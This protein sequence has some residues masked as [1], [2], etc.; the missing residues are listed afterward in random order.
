MIDVSAVARG[1]YGGSL[2]ATQCRYAFQGFRIVFDILDGLIRHPRIAVVG[3]F[4]II[5]VEVFGYLDGIAHSKCAFGIE[6]LLHAT[7]YFSGLRCEHVFDRVWKIRGCQLE[8]TR[9]AE[10]VI[11]VGWID[12]DGTDVRVGFV[13]QGEFDPSFAFANDG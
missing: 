1:A 5:E 6:T 2:R 4:R 10:R 11:R 8:G 12:C 7:Y 9:F 13:V 3:L